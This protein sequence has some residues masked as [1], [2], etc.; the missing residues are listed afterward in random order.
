MLVNADCAA[1]QSAQTSA[2][3]V[4]LP[5]ASGWEAWRNGSQSI[6]RR[7]WGRQPT[8]ENA[9][10]K[11]MVPLWSALLHGGGGEF[12]GGINVNSPIWSANRA[13]IGLARARS[14]S[15]PTLPDTCSPFFS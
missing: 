10:T 4:R 1:A 11:A 9:A 8:L 15:A 7:R 2:R 12:K 3:G 6:L 13:D 5:L 14:P